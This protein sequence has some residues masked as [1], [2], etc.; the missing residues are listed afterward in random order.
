M[1]KIFIG[2]DVS[3][4]SNKL[5]KGL[6]TNPKL[7]LVGDPDTQARWYYDLKKQWIKAQEENVPFVN[8]LETQKLHWVT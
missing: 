4:F 7:M 5:K 3:I 8:T 1:G 6:E 2:Q